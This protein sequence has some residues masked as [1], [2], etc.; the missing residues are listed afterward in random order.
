MNRKKCE[1]SFRLFGKQIKCLFS[2]KQCVESE[3]FKI[4]KDISHL[5]KPLVYMM[6]NFTD[7]KINEFDELVHYKL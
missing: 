6:T 4:S 2:N 1:K 7:N 3:E 5:V